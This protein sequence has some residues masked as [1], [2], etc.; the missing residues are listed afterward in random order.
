MSILQGK[1]QCLVAVIV[2]NGDVRTMG[3]QRLDDL[4]LALGSGEHQGGAPH[5]VERIDLR[6]TIEQQLHGFRMTVVGRHHQGRTPVWIDG[7]GRCPLIK[8]GPNP[9]NPPIQCGK[10]EGLLELILQFR[11]LSPGSEPKP[12]KGNGKQDG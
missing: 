4:D 6:S 1:I 5:K 3:K 12:C 10:P 11:R 7:I 9:L 8:T 2:L